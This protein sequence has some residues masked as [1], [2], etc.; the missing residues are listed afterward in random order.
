MCGASGLGIACGG[1]LSLDGVDRSSD[2]Q[3][4]ATQGCGRK[5]NN[6]KKLMIAASAAL[7]AAVGFSDITS[8]NIVGYQNKDIPEYLSVQV[9][10]FDQVG[11]GGLSLDQFVPK[12]STGS[13]VGGGD[14]TIQFLDEFGVAQYGY[15]YYL[16]GELKKKPDDG[17][18]DEDEELIEGYEF[19][20]GE[21]MMIFSGSSDCVFPYAGEVVMNETDVPFVPY[22]S[23]QGNIRPTSVDIQGIQPIDASENLIGGGSVTLQF[24]DQFGV[25]QYGY[26]YYLG[27]ELKKKPDD[28]WYDEDEELVEYEFGAGEG[29]LL[30]TDTEGFLR[31]PEL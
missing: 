4:N 21:G 17:W 16:G 11:G 13:A 1:A 28:G 20:P 23:A 27:G 25:A 2:L 8:A 22:L 24:L 3:S 31:Y 19:N 10:T 7:C 9:N 14:V 30:Y 15:S 18:Y 12:D 26:S 29:F 6:M 5:M